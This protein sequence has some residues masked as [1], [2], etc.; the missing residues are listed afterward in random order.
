M[1]LSILITER[2]AVVKEEQIKDLALQDLEF[3]AHVRFIWICSYYAFIIFLRNT[4]SNKG[5]E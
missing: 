4:I 2:N 3:A 1:I 5:Y